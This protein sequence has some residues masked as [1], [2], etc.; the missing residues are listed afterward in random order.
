MRNVRQALTAH[1]QTRLLKLPVNLE[2]T[3]LVTQPRV[4][5]VPPVWSAPTQMGQE[6][7]LASLVTLVSADKQP[8]QNVKQAI[9][10]PPLPLQL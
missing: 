3:V 4:P 10:A 5:P 1:T 2:R 8:V 6:L 9:R 7:H